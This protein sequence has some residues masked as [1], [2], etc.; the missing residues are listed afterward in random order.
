MFALCL[1]TLLD[2]VVLV[3]FWVDFTSYSQYIYI[4]FLPL[5]YCID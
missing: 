2:S 1:V 3:V 5:A 4:S